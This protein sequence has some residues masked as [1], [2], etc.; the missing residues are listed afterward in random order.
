MTL[1]SPSALEA[2]PRVAAIVQV[3]ADPDI[4]LLTWARNTVVEKDAP[5]LA[6]AVQAKVD[7]LVTGD[8]RDFGHLFSTTQRGVLVM[9]PAE[10]VRRL[11]AELEDPGT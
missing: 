4:D 5:I 8:R 7:W 3:T 1:K 6:C 2:W 11:L 10:G 9:P